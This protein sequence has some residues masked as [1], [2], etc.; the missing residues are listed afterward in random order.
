MSCPP[1]PPPWSC[2]PSG[3]W[4][5]PWNSTCKQAEQAWRWRRALATLPPTP[6]LVSK[7]TKRS[8]LD[9]STSHCLTR[10]QAHMVGL[11]TSMGAM[12]SSGCMITPASR[13]STAAACTWHRQGAMVGEKSHQ[14]GGWTRNERAA[15]RPPP[16]ASGTGNPPSAADRV[17]GNVVGSSWKQQLEGGPAG[18]R[19][20]QQGSTSTTQALMQRAR[21]QCSRTA[22][23]PAAAH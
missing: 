11:R 15:G 8:C 23:A 19:R 13:W 22:A 1:Q 10:P 9:A 2:K 12:C 21:E 17:R 20:P 5:A 4:H 14:A 6:P 7:Q 3:E 18:L 16:H